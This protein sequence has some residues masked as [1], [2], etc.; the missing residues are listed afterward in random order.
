MPEPAEFEPRPILQKLLEHRARRQAA[1]CT[2][3]RCVPARCPHFTFETLYGSIDILTD[4]DGAP[5]YDRLKAAAGRP[6]EVE[7]EHIFVASLDHLIAMKETS[8]RTKDKL[9]ATEDR[10]LSD[11]LRVRNTR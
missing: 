2:A 8:D 11:Q 5:S 7:G 9:M 6:A 1:R 10:V 4:P 3:R